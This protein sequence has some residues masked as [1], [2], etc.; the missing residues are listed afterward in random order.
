MDI[1][2]SDAFLDMPQSSQLLYFHLSMRADD[3]GFLGN[4]KSIQRGIG[5]SD[6]DLK[7]L[8]AKRFLLVFKSGVIVVKHWRINNT[9]RR[10]RYNPTKY[11]EEKS[12]VFLKL[13]GSYTDD[14]ASGKPL[15]NQ[16]A[17]QKRIEEDRID[18]SNDKEPENAKAR[19]RTRQVLEARGILV[20]KKK[21]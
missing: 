16:L 15:G 21:A 5:S 4:P 3:D 11:T 6:D 14:S 7:I 8:F 20:S 12:N 17:T 13:N 2:G 1:V 10:D 19:Q 18:M 9:I